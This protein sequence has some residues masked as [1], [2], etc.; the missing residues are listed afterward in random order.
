[1]ILDVTFE[2]QSEVFDTSFK[3]H[4]KP[5]PTDFNETSQSLNSKLSENTELFDFELDEKVK[6]FVSDFGEIYRVGTEDDTPLY[7]LVT[8]DGQEIPAVMVEEEVNFDAT[9]NDIRIGKVAATNEGV[10]IGEKVIPSYNTYTGARLVT[11]NSSFKIPNMD[12]RI[13]YYDYTKLQS[14]ICLF[15]TNVSKS[16][17]AEKVS[18]DDNLYDVRS[19]EPISTIVKNHDTKSIDFGIVN[20]LG[21]HCV[22]RYF[23]Y[24]E[25]Y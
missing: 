1:M 15:N 3:E 2:D 5:T 22:I 19:S 21:T 10:T 23:T 14:I 6:Y 24:K 8:E 16:V 9:A 7:V 12:S 20:D 18:I 4:S 25:I 17:S 13:D 11:K